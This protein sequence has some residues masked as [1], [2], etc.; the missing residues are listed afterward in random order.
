MVDIIKHKSRPIYANFRRMNIPKIIQLFTFSILWKTFVVVYIICMLPLP[1][2]RPNQIQT[3]QSESCNVTMNGIGNKTHIH[4]HKGTEMI[5]TNDEFDW[6][7]HESRAKTTNILYIILTYTKKT[8][9]QPLQMEHY[10]IWIDEFSPSP[11]LSLSTQFD[12]YNIM[13]ESL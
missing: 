1:W 6:D 3:F 12:R 10:S 7:I 4:I 11:S 5:K 9:I 13:C 8:T 2:C